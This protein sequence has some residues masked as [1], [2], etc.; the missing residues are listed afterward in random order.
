M[1]KLPARLR[2]KRPD[3]ARLARPKVVFLRHGGGSALM[4]AAFDGRSRL[5]K[6]HRAHVEALRAHL[7][8]EPSVPQV[9]L[10]DQA[11]KLRLLAQIAWGELMQSGAFRRG[12][13]RPAFDAFRR[14]AADEREV[15]RLLG[16][17]R[18]AGEIPDVAAEIARQRR[19]EEAH[20]P[21]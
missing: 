18:R 19:E 14:A 6:Q 2:T 11:A 16:L 4:R 12:E 17:E 8:G 1:P 9:A 5:G 10:I 3:S 21:A 7:G 13:S 15:L 20:A